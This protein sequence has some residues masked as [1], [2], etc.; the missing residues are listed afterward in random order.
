LDLQ[1]RSL[2]ASNS[3]EAKKCWLRQ[4]SG[5]AQRSVT[6]NGGLDVRGGARL[7]RGAF[8]SRVLRRSENLYNQLLKF[9]FDEW[10]TEE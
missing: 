8:L 9:I 5:K 1:I 4:D 2:G 6:M 7:K 3:T 10:K